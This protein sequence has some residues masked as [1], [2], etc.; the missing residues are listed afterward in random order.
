MLGHTNK[1]WEGIHSFQ[2]DIIW[3]IKEKFGDAVEGMKVVKTPFS[4]E[5]AVKWPSE[6]EEKMTTERQT[7]YQS[8]VRS[9]LYLVK[10]SRPDLAHAAKELAKVIDGGTKKHYEQLL[11]VV[12]YVL[13]TKR[14]GVALKPKKLEG[15]LK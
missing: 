15:D 3:K 4:A 12:N 11:W 2:P 14:K 5:E 8:G 10:H 13:S 1:R 6:K 9:L 7:E